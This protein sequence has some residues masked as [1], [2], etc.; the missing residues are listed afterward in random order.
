MQ[1]KKRVIESKI[2]SELLLTMCQPS[3]KNYYVSE[4]VEILRPDPMSKD[5][6]KTQ[7]IIRKQ[8]IYLY[9]QGFLG[10][11]EKGKNFDKNKKFFF[12]KWEKVVETFINYLLSLKVHNIESLNYDN[13]TLTEYQHKGLK[14]NINNFKKK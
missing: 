1:V 12:I 6:A 7:P 13:I 8:I 5:K 14:A 2:Y 10:T 3:K 4:I 9:E 11:T